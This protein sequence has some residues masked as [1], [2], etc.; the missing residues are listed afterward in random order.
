MGTDAVEL[1]TNVYR[2]FAAGDL[3]FVM[4]SLSEDS[5]W[6]VSGTNPVSGDYVGKQQVGAFLMKLVQLS[7][8]TF[9]ISP[10]YIMSDGNRCMSVLRYTAVRNGRELDI[11]MVHV[12]HLRDGK[13]AEYWN[14]TKD[15]ELLNDFWA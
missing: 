9:R 5:A 8:G 14:Y 3:N 12:W 13:L 7:S 11:S 6:H 4:S 2:A 10:Q 1:L 15:Q